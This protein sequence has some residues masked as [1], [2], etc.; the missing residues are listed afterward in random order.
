MRV[1]RSG[2][3]AF[4]EERRVSRDFTF[5]LI[6]V[7]VGSGEIR[8]IGRAGDCN[9]A[10]GAAADGANLFALGGTETPNFPF[11]ANWT[12]Q[13]NSLTRTGEKNT[14]RNKKCKIDV[15]DYAMITL[16]WKRR[17][18]MVKRTVPRMQSARPSFHK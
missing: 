10:L 11:F 3:K 12:R 5:V 16:L 2:W 18:A 6:L 7:A 8:A 14:L 9:F 1:Q 17:A 15:S 4:F 13:T